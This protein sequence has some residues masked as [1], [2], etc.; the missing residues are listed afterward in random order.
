MPDVTQRNSL[1]MNLVYSAIVYGKLKRVG[2]GEWD[3]M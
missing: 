1:N 2:D 3:A